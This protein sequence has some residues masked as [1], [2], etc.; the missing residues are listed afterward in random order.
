M[1]AIAIVSHRT[2]SVRCPPAGRWCAFY[3]RPG[4]TMMDAAHWSALLDSQHPMSGE[5]RE[6][7]DRGLVG[8]QDVTP[9]P[10]PVV[11][12]PLPEP[13]AER[14]TTDGDGLGAPPLDVIAEEV[15]A[16]GV[17]RRSRRRKK[18]GE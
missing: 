4:V 7:V 2:S 15:I 12:A 11:S 8:P 18:G 3:L 17:V 5:L 1:T 6:H 9:A 13:V 10:A 16:A 14:L